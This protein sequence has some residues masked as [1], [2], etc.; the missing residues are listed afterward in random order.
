MALRAKLSGDSQHAAQWSGACFKPAPIRQY[1]SNAPET[2]AALGRYIE[3]CREHDKGTA[4]DALIGRLCTGRCRRG[5]ATNT[6]RETRLPLHARSL[7]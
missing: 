2:L 7:R 4:I 5:G 6:K 3:W 1:E